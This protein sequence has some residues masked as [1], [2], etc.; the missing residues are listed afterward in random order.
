MSPFHRLFSTVRL[1][2]PL[3]IIRHALPYGRHISLLSGA[4]KVFKTQESQVLD[5]ITAVPFYELTSAPA[6]IQLNWL[7]LFLDAVFTFVPLPLIYIAQ[8][9]NTCRTQ[10]CRRRSGLAILDIRSPWRRRRGTSQART[11]TCQPPPRPRMLPRRHR[12]RRCPTAH[13]R[14]TFARPEA[15][16]IPCIR[17]RKLPPRKGAA[18]SGHRRGRELLAVQFPGRVYAGAERVSVCWA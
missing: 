14:A 9:T 8:S 6:P 13:Q 18:V 3:H 11:S 15:L 5:K 1:Q 2:S 10:R 17:P 7:F 4:K 12:I 16:V